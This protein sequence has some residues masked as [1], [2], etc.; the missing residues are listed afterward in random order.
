MRGNSMKRICNKLINDG[1]DL[2]SF[3]A[4]DFFARQGDWQTI[5]YY[6]LVKNLE[7]WEIDKTFESQLKKNLPNA[8]IKIVDSYFEAEKCKNTFDFIVFDNPQMCFGPGEKYCEHFEA[9]D[10]VF[11]LAKK[12]VIIIFN[13]NHNPFDLNKNNKWKERRSQ[14]YSVKD[15]SKLSKENFVMPFYVNFF[16]K[17]HLKTLD[18]FFE[19]RNEDYLSNFIFILEKI[20]SS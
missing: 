11:R 9:L 12:Q 4:L 6:N 18:C 8:T 19:D 2:N 7:V 14:F 13:V 1:Y 20:K 17:N 16:K 5:S 10:K 3:N 15:T